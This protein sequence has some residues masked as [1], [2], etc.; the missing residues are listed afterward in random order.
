[1]E[2]LKPHRQQYSFTF[3]LVSILL[4]TCNA[5]L[6]HGNSRVWALVP[7]IALPRCMW[8]FWIA[9]S[10]QGA[11]CASVMLWVQVQPS[12]PNWMS[13]PLCLLGFSIVNLCLRWGYRVN[14]VF[15]QQESDSPQLS[16][17]INLNQPHTRKHA[18][19]SHSAVLTQPR[20]HKHTGVSHS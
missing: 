20:E 12:A 3:L 17:S 15:Y 11:L 10:I 6:Q 4:L 13:F 9:V 2:L 1:M 7:D 5:D 8:V 18:Q 19:V 14:M 16:T